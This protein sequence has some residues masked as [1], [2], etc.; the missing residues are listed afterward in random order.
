MPIEPAAPTADTVYLNT[1]ELAERWR[2]DPD[3][4]NNLR[5]RGEGIPFTKTTGRPL[6]N[7]A[8]V[9]AAETAGQHGFTWQKL[10]DALGE[11]IELPP[12]E[13]ERVMAKLRKAMK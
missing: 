6:Y 10:S 9:L 1:R 8:D 13:H 2:I 7:L 12:A 11:V 5:Y 3:T 4:L